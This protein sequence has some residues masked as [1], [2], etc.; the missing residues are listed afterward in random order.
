MAV[1]QISSF[2]A[3]SPLIDYLT[4]FVDSSDGDLK[5]KDY[6]GVVQPVSEYISG[7]GGSVYFNPDQFTG[8]GASALDPIN[9]KL[10]TSGEDAVLTYNTNGLGVALA[11]TTLPTATRVNAW[12]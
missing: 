3:E 10:Q 4:L 6:F 11:S 1:L 2:N 5:I 7:G 12:S 8:T 9:V